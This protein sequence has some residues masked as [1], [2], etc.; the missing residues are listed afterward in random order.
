MLPSAV[1]LLSFSVADVVRILVYGLMVA[2]VLSARGVWPFVGNV[3]MYGEYGCTTLF[4]ACLRHC[5]GDGT[6]QPLYCSHA[7][8]SHGAM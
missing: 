3:R 2:V 7:H 6:V 8:T 4:V 5:G 1:P